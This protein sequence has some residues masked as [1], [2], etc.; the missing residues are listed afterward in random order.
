MPDGSGNAAQ[1]RMVAEQVAE[2]T[3][4][5]FAS[6]A[7]PEAEIPPPLKWAGGIIALFTLG[8]GGMAVWL[9]TSVNEMQV[10]LAR[11]DERMAGASASADARLSS[12]EGRVL[13][14]EGYHRNSN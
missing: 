14:L 6:K 9:I 1:V 5:K 10:T 12:V 8:I 3:L 2:A 7:K 4:V 13:T 11:M